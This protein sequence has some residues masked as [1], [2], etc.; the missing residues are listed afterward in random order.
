MVILVY[1]PSRLKKHELL[2][3]PLDHIL[4]TTKAREQVRIQGPGIDWV[5]DLPRIWE[6]ERKGHLFQRKK[7]ILS[8]YLE[9]GDKKSFFFFF[10]GGGGG[11]GN[12][13]LLGNMGNTIDLSF[14]IFGEKENKPI[15][16]KG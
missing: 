12:F 6:N 16:Y 2:L 4:Q 13:T 3:P 8:L 10:F 9:H 14:F 11:G 15:H 1:L 7:N 5:K